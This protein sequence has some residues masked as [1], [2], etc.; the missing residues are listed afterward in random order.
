MS[1]PSASLKKAIAWADGS[2]ISSGDHGE[3]LGKDGTY[4]FEDKRIRQARR[5]YAWASLTWNPV[6][7]FSGFVGAQAWQ[8]VEC[9]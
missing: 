4:N 6:W 7:H 1:M 8:E 9:P 3:M 5:C 2:W